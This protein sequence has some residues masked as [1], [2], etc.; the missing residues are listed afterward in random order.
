MSLSQLKE[1]F[2]RDALAILERDPKA[3]AQLEAWL[4]ESGPGK[5]KAKEIARM[6]DQALAGRADPEG[7]R[8]AAQRVWAELKEAAPEA[9]ARQAEELLANLAADPWAIVYLKRLFKVLA[10]RQNRPELL[11]SSYL[12]EA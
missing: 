7:R 9:H 6:M 11:G 1:R 10:R 3:Y 4:N 2:R 12:S 5:V 8:L